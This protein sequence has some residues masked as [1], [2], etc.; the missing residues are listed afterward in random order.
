MER[1]A[2]LEVF[3]PDIDDWETYA[4]RLEQSFGVNGVKRTSE[5]TESGITNYMR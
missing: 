5:R 2:R 3:V 4:E 1:Y